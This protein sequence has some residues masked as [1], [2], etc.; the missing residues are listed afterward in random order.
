MA[1]PLPVSEPADEYAL[2]RVAE[3]AA[4][5][6]GCSAAGVTIVRPQGRPVL[7][8][9]S[10]LGLELEATQWDAGEGP[11]LDAM[12][13]LQVFNVACLVTAQSWPDFVPRALGRGIRSCLAVPII[14]RGRAVGALD[15]YSL[16]TDAFVGFEQ[17]GLHFAGEAAM[18]LALVDDGAPVPASGE[19]HPSADRSRSRAVS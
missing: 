11:G 16:E 2:R 19:A 15:L 18:A 9:T 3:Q 4:S 5:A 10:I 6:A 13:Q 12:G 1:L 8:G 17:V 7:V 14:L